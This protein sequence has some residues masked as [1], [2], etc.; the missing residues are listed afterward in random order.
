MN[1]FVNRL[2]SMGNRIAVS[3]SNFFWPDHEAIV[4]ISKKLV[5]IEQSLDS[6]SSLE[7]CPK[8]DVS[9]I[10]ECVNELKEM[11]PNLES[12][13]NKA[14]E[15][16]E[17]FDNQYIKTLQEENV[18]IHEDTNLKLMRKYVLDTQ[19]RLYLQIAN[20]VS[21]LGDELELR[22]VLELIKDNLSEVG[23][24]FY[25]SKNGTLFDS[26]CM[27]LSLK[28]SKYTNDKSL[29]KTVACSIAPKFV[30]N[31][32]VLGN[33]NQS[34]ILRKEEVILWKYTENDKILDHQDRYNDE[35]PK[36][37]ESDEHIARPND[38]DNHK[39]SAFLVM[40]LDGEIS[41]VYSVCDGLNIY[42]K[43]PRPIENGS[44]HRINIINDNLSSEHFSIDYDIESRIAL[45]K[46][47]SGQF[48]INNPGHCPNSSELETG[49]EIVIDN[50]KFTLING[51]D[52]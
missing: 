37:Q 38:S 21:D 32:P 39:I 52:E 15:P 44:V 36:V 11:I 14:Q 27:Q 5:D 20:R 24:S 51:T 31:V 47:I 49:D 19:I 2:K 48:H 41:N 7:T 9:N 50:L 22:K 16:C 8:V 30:W 33:N 1:E 45:F 28:D 34:F 29:D 3:L 25:S 17:V 42:G 12:S 23:V 35:I 40:Q 46:T 18:R 43:N 26:Q 4:S 13:F 6:I 10:I